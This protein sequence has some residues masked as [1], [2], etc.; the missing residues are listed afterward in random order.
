MCI[1]LPGSFWPIVLGIIIILAG[2]GFYFE[3]DT[4]PLILGLIAILIIVG[5]VLRSRRR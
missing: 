5:A 4:G 3:V 2:I 1:G